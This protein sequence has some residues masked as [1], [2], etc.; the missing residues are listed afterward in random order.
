MA[1]G[2]YSTSRFIIQE[3]PGAQS[4]PGVVGAA[5]P[6][7]LSIPTD[8]Y[9]PLWRH[10]ATPRLEEHI[11]EG[12]LNGTECNFIKKYNDTVV[13]VTWDGSLRVIGCK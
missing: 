7:S 2:F 13:K 1:T 12:A 4:P 11:D 10:C 3:L 5:P 9:Q 8:S 6:P